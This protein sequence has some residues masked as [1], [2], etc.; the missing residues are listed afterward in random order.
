MMIWGVLFTMGR[1]V[2]RNSFLLFV[3]A[4]SLI[5]LSRVTAQ[6][7][8]Q[9][10]PPSPKGGGGMPRPA[11]P[12]RV[13]WEY[14]VEYDY[15]LVKQ[16]KGDLQAGL[17][18]LGGDAWELITVEPASTSRTGTFI[19][20]RPVAGQTKAEK[21]PALEKTPTEKA[22]P[23]MELRMYTIK[24]ADA[25][26]LSQLINEVLRNPNRPMRIVA[27]PRTNQLVVNTT[28]ESHTEILK[29]LDRLDTPSDNEKPKTKRKGQ[30]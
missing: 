30:R 18:A 27:E 25:R 12:M 24:F 10:P 2:V 20:R 8:K 11:D 21:K 7:P 9:G 4:I 14:R 15:S 13:R 29:L 17:N 19:F 16:G 5:G 28:M 1:R 6:G 3:V 23:Q 26:E 22:E